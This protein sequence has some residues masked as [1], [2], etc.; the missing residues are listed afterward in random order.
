MPFTCVGPQSREVDREA[1]ILSLCTRNFKRGTIV[2]F[3][4]KVTAH[5]MAILMGLS[6][7]KCGELHGNLSQQQR[8]DAYD[9]FAAGVCVCHLCACVCIC[10]CVCPVVHAYVCVFVCACMCV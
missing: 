8:Q 1:M 3:D 9:D 6:S 5:R 2:F 7:L 4:K 10:M